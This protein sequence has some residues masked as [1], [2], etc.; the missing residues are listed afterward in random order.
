M[1]CNIGHPNLSADISY[2]GSI[3]NLPERVY[4]LF[5]TAF[6]PRHFW[7]VF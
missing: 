2:L 6:F 1:E 5:L 3:F 7:W 4:Y